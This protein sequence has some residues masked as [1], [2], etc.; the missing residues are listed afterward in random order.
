MTHQDI[1]NRSLLLAKAVVYKIENS[2]GP[3]GIEK[4]KSVCDK[5][6][7]KQT[8]NDIIEWKRILAQPWGKIKSVL[9]DQSETGCRLRQSNPF[10]GIL[11]PKERWRIYKEFGEENR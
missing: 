2:L 11:S 5:W 6:L 10:C 7:N 8:G 4:A 9:L 1:D 3:I